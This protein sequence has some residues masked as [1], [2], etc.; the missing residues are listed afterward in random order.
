MTLNN[1]TPF[2]G[3][4]QSSEY[5]ASTGHSYSRYAWVIL[6]VSF[7]GLVI[8]WG[9]WRSFG[10]FL[11]PLLEE[12]GW[13]RAETTG[14]TIVFSLMN[15]IVGIYLGRLVDRHGPRLIIPVFGAV[16]GIGLIL[17]SQTTSLWHLY[18]SY[19]LIVGAGSTVSYIPF[20][21]TVSQWFQERRGTI[22]GILIS[23]I[24]VGM[25]IVPPMTQVLILNVGWR[26]S[27]IVLGVFLCV[28]MIIA[29]ILLK[30][31]PGRKTTQTNAKTETKPEL[32]Y[33]EPGSGEL[34]VRMV[35]KTRAFWLLFFTYIALTVCLEMTSVHIVAYAID[36]NILA[37]VAAT[38]LTVIGAA[39]I[40]GKLT[41]GAL[42]DKIG[43]KVSLTGTMALL[44]LSLACLPFARN[45][46]ALF[47]FAAVFGIAYGGY[48]P[49][50]PAF[51]GDMF[52]LRSMGTLMGLITLGAGI[53]SAIGPVL[54]G[55]I[56]DVQS[57]YNIAFW[58][59]AGIAVL[60][61]LAASQVKSP[62]KT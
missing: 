54:A 25:A 57:S 14:P 43:R 55:Y 60:A 17:A 19:G 34:S 47:A 32:A 21:S 48:A 7:A 58:L 4:G 3:E 62:R 53:G 16:M 18:L 45:L 23:G 36:M 2:S 11:K 52:G 15:G 50:I 33:Q 38:L 35:L 29:G 59:A 22:L 8:C 6:A 12:F 9:T 56:F 10:V 24:G 1:K 5:R 41:I 44:G 49:L 51:I 37:A 30:L 27:F 13:S 40:L 46:P 26:L 28:A 61:A 39:S 31:P 42:S 20:V